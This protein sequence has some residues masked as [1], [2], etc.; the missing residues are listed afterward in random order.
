LQFFIR[1][2]V[3]NYDS[4]EALEEIVDENY[5]NTSNYLLDIL[6]TRYKLKDHLN[7]LK[8]Y[9]LLGQGDFIQNLMDSLG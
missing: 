2:I 9:L 7:A 3:F 4:I 6:F 8:R 1:F 5:I